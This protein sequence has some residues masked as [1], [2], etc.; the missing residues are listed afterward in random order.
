M[1]VADRLAGPW[2]DVP[3][4]SL[5]DMHGS[6]GPA[7]FRLPSLDGSRKDGDW[8]LMLDFVSKSEGYKTFTTSDLASGVFAPDNEIKFPF[9]FR[10][11]SVLSLSAG[12]YNRVKFAYEIA[13]HRMPN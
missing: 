9:A 10:H 4:Y 6:E 13:Q 12:E 3:G 8:C 1:E 11:G 2:T 5:A 7:A